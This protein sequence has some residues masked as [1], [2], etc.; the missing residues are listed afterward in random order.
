MQLSQPVNLTYVRDHHYNHLSMI[1]SIQAIIS[2]FFI[3][4]G[5]ALSLSLIGI[6]AMGFGNINK[7]RYEIGIRR[8]IGA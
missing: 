6:Y 8:A 2:V 4:G 3:V 7:S 1:N 5:F